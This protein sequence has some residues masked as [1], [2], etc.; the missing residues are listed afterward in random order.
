MDLGGAA[1]VAGYGTGAR[2][3]YLLV[4]L[5]F[6]L[7]T[8]LA[9]MVGTAIGAGQRARALQG[10]GFSYLTAGWPSGGAERVEEFAREVLP[11]FIG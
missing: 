8:P 6:G 4:P 2:L 3:E 9:T 7:G 1:A 11:E 10:I 5:V